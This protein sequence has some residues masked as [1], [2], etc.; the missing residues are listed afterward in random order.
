MAHHLFIVSREKV[1]LFEYLLERFAGDRDVTVVLDRRR[2][3]DARAR[4]PLAP[5][6]IERR[7]PR[8]QEAARDLALQGYFV[9]DL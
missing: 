7:T 6:L 2:G 4:H 8:T 1:W 9:V 5:P 3:D